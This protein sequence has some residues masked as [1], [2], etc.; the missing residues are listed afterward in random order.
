MQY[1]RGAPVLVACVGVAYFALQRY[2]SGEGWV[3]GETAV[4]IEELF[5]EQSDSPEA[6][7]EALIARTLPTLRQ[8]PCATNCKSGDNCCAVLDVGCGSGAL[9]AA[10]AAEQPDWRVVCSDPSAELLQLAATNQRQLETVQASADNL[11]TQTAGVPFEPASFD[12][13]LSLNSLRFWSNPGRGLQLIHTLLRHDGYP[14]PSL[15]GRVTAEPKPVARRVLILSDWSRDSLAC[16]L[17]SLALEVWDRPRKEFHFAT[18][19]LASSLLTAA[20]FDL[21]SLGGESPHREPR[22]SCSLLRNMA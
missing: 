1:L 18:E 7:V 6:V 16:R 2:N 3:G 17:Y 15:H 14:L 11:Q 12:A 10:L 9:A 5:G 13:V 21:F 4:P 8:L 22:C 19:K 20:G